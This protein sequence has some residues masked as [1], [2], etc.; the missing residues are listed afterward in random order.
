MLFGG[1][2]GEQGL[3]NDVYIIDLHTMVITFCEHLTLNLVLNHVSFMLG[4]VYNSLCN[5]ISWAIAFCSQ[6]V[7]DVSMGI[8]DLPLP[9]GAVLIGHTLQSVYVYTIF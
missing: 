4:V 7:A 2:N 3:M 1:C 5:S 6:S 9:L 8:V